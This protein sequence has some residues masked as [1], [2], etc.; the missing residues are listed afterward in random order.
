MAA[1]SAVAPS[2][3]HNDPAWRQQALSKERELLR[4]FLL[5]NRNECG[6][7]DKEDFDGHE[8][9]YSQSNAM[10]Q[11]IRWVEELLGEEED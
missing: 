3:T 6:L 7:L 8:T 2:P 11:L 4:C 9:T 1:S 10:T 5:L